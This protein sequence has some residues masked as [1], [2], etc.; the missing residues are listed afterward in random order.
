MRGASKYLFTQ[1]PI[2]VRHVIIAGDSGFGD[3]ETEDI[4]EQPEQSAVVHTARSVFQDMVDVFQ[5]EA[6]GNLYR[7]RDMLPVFGIDNSGSQLV[8]KL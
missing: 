2:R 8:S 7:L 1:F 5:C 3:F 4:A 6:D